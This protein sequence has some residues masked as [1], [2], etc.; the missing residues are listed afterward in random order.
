MTEGEKKKIRHLLDYWGNSYRITRELEIDIA[1][2]KDIRKSIYE[3]KSMW[4]DDRTLGNPTI[5]FDE[6]I[7]RNIKLCA[8]LIRQ[9]SIKLEKALRIKGTLDNIIETLED[10]Q[11]LVIRGK[12]INK[13]NWEMLPLNLPFLISKRHVQRIYNEA[14]NIIFNA[15]ENNEELKWFLENIDNDENSSWAS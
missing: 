10:T 8:E 3:I 2:Y 12:H 1:K 7:N 5:D 9:T 4:S 15:L 6:R 13:L 14:L 11:L